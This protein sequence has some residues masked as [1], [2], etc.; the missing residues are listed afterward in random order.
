MFGT[1]IVFIWSSMGRNNLLC[2]CQESYIVVFYLLFS[3]QC[4]AEIVAKFVNGKKDPDNEN[5]TKQMHAPDWLNERWRILR[6]AFQ[7][8]EGVH[9]YR[10][11][12]VMG[13]V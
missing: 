9:F 4:L 6:G 12:L 11:V 13:P 8:I 5:E 1:I 3:M 7:P 2:F 10:F